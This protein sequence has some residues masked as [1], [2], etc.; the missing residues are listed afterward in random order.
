LWLNLGIFE[1]SSHE[2]LLDDYT[3][4][5]AWVE[6]KRERVARPE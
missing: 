6:L 1:I 5:A 4:K 3:E 2:S